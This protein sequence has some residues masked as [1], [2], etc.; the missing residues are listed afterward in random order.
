MA[1]R[2]LRKYRSF[3]RGEGLRVNLR[4]REVGFA[5][6]GVG[7][8]ELSEDQAGE[9][10]QDAREIQVGEHPVDPVELLSHILQEEDGSAEVGLK[11]GAEEACHEGTAT[12]KQSP[13]GPARP[14][15]DGRL[16]GGMRQ[17][18]T[19]GLGCQESPELF[20]G[21]GVRL[22]PEFHRRHGTR[23]GDETTAPPESELKESEIRITDQDFWVT[24]CRPEV[25]VG[26]KP[27]AAIPAAQGEDRA[28]PGIPEHRVHVGRPLGVGSR[29]ESMTF[30][31]VF[32]Q[33]NP[34]PEAFQ[35]PDALLDP[36]GRLRWAGR[37]DET[38]DITAAKSGRTDG[39]HRG[40]VPGGGVRVTRALTG[41]KEGRDGG[42]P[43]PTTRLTEG[44]GSPSVPGS[45]RSNA[46][47]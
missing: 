15:G 4:Q 27:A 45:L 40:R 11:P 41:A 24:P 32:P 47:Q 28:D 20:L 9:A 25:Q 43:I 19:G 34:V 16:P 18:A 5:G 10:W 2:H 22:V 21:P 8:G 3:E 23:K 38:D 1:V 36:L 39:F 26:K 33:L 46:V 42:I 13:L 6:F 7:F 14:Q 31:D 29:G 44:R 12:S 35:V 30:E 17:G 37:R